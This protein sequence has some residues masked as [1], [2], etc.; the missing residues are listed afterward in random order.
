[1]D[2]NNVSASFIFLFIINNV[3]NNISNLK[4]KDLHEY[5]STLTLLDPLEKALLLHIP[6]FLM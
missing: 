3:N 1:M 6:P 5:D 4:N 2:K